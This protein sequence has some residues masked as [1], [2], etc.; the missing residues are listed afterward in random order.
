ML[1]YS[2]ERANPA[3]VNLGSRLRGN[4]KNQ[5]FAKINITINFNLMNLVSFKESK[6]K[7]FSLVEISI[8]ILVIGILITGTIYG[9]SFLG[10]YRLSAAQKST[11]IHQLIK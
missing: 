9:V 2:R 3:L 6:N 8:V 10:K 11:K 5:N 4:D 1:C 7:A